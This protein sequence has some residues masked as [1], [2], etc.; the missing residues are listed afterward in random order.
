M[1]GCGFKVYAFGVFVH[2]G[3]VAAHDAGECDGAVVVND[4]HVVGGEGDGFLVEE[5][6]GFA[7]ACLSH[8]EC[9]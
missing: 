9:A 2:F 4:D 8:A 1:K 5:Q 6:D 3:V 7:G